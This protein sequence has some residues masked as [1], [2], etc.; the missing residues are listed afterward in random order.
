MGILKLVLVLATLAIVGVDIYLA[1]QS[2]FTCKSTL[3]KF[4]DHRPRHGTN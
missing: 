3:Y 1:S 4:P 2:E